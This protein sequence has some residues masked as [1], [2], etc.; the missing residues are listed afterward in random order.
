MELAEFSYTIQYREECSN[1]VPDSFTR[2]KCDSIFN[3]PEDIHAQLCHPG[4]TRLPHFV[5]TKNLPYS[6]D[7]VKKACSNC[8]ICAELKPKFYKPDS[9][10]LIRS[11]RPM[12][13]VNI[14]F[15]GSLPSVSRN[16]DFLTVI[17]EYSRFPFVIPCPNVSA[18]SLIKYLDSVFALCGIP[19]FA[20]SDRG[21]AFI[22]AE[23]TSYL[24]SRDI[25]SS[26]STPYYPIGNGQVERYNGIVWKSIQLVLASAKLPVERWES[27]LPDVLHSTRS[28]LSTAHNT[29]RH[30]T[31]TQHHAI[32]REIQP[33]VI[34]YPHRC[35]LAL[36]CYV[37][38]SVQVSMISW[39]RKLN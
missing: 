34:H 23:L 11:T 7:E 13:Q 31:S 6:T 18:S 19:G 36:C 17:D 12:E 28:L 5:K 39:F 2:V 38:L 37:S 25:A 33:K 30:H 14:D 4:V 26:H 35:L 10:T 29:T 1:V 8:T 21:S 27:V 24:T 15:K 20:H 3:N 22:S 16:K 32:S 9:S